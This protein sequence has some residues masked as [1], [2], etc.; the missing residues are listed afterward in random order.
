MDVEENRE[1]ESLAIPS[2]HFS[3]HQSKSCNWFHIWVRPYTNIDLQGAAM[4][5]RLPK[6]FL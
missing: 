2:S 4:L 3:K 6:V 1:A 5:P